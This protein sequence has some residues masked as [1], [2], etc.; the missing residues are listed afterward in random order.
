MIDPSCKLCIRW[1]SRGDD[2]GAC[3]KPWPDGLTPENPRI[4]AAEDY[5]P[6]FILRMPQRR[7]GDG[8]SGDGKP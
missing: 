2:L 4:T 3:R 8:E 1:K 6:E 5:C 7:I